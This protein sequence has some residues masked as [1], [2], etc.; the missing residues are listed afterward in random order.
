MHL[1]KNWFKLVL[2][3][4]N[5]F[6][7]FRTF[8]WFII[9]IAAFSVRDD[10]LGVSSFVRALWILPCNY[11]RLLDFFNSSAIS[12]V[13]LKCLWTQCVLKNF[14]LIRL[15]KR[16][17]LVADGLKIPKSGK[18]MPAVKLL[19]QQSDNNNKPEFI[20]GHSCQSVGILGGFKEKTVFSVPLTTDIHEGFI[21]NSS[22]NKTL[23]DKMNNMIQSLNIDENAYLIVDAYYNSKNFFIQKPKNIDIITRVRNNGI[24][25]EKIKSQ[26]SKKRGRPKI[27]GKKLK[28][29]HFFNKPNLFKTINSPLPNEA[30]IKLQIYSNNF[31][32]RVNGGLLCKFL[33]VI[34]PKKGCI[35]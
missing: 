30:H 9:V 26:T 12:L 33:L 24:A 27:Y 7:R 16:I 23:L 8:Q 3:L 5:A 35:I 34:H 18:H 19:H 31:L 22:D 6:S 28:L 13:N 25:Y 2:Q 1:W 20:N 11:K 10:L 17:L 21:E 4:R 32:I 14:P 15:N 29:N